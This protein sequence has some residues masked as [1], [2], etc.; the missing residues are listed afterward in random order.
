ML[1]SVMITNPHPSVK[2][3][4]RRF[5]EQYPQYHASPK[6]EAFY[7][8][9]NE[10]DA[11]ECADLVIEGIKQATS[12]SLWWFN[13]HNK[14]LPEAGNLYIITDWEGMAKAIVQ[15]TKVEQV[16]YS[17]IDEAYARIEGEGDQ[18]LEYWRKA[19]WAY[20]EREMAPFGEQPSESMIIVCEQFETIWT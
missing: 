4:W 17:D 3:M 14:P 15:T 7:F 12:T 10:N 16:P 19:H 1:Y 6:P 20:Y 5:L 8:C 2:S 13:K 18:S 11:N 9:D